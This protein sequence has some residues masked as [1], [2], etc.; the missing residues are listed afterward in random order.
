M[1]RPSPATTSS[2]LALPHG[3]SGAIA[4]E[5]PAEHA[6]ARLRRRPPP[7]DEADWAR[8]YGGELRRRLAL[9]PARAAPRRRHRSATPSRAPR[10][11]AVPGCNVTAVTLA[12]AP[13]IAR[14]RHRGARPRRRARRRARAGRASAA[15]RPA[16]QRAARLGR[17]PTASAASHRHIPEILQN[18]A[19]R[20]RR[21]RE[22]S[23]SR[24]CSCRCPAASSRPATA[25]LAAGRRLPRA[26]ATR[27][28]PPTPTSP[29][30]TC[31]PR[32]SCPRTADDRRREHGAHRARGRRGARAASSSISAIDNLVKGTAGA[33]V[34]SLN[35]ALGLPETTGLTSG[36]SR[37]RERHRSP[38]AS[39][40]AGVA[41]GLKSSGAPDLALV[42]NR[43]PLQRRGRRLHEQPRARPTRHLVAAGRSPT[44]RSRRSC[45]TRAAPTAS[46]ARRASRPRTPPPS[47]SREALEV[48]AG[49]V[50]VCS[51]GP[52]RR[53]AAAR[54]VLAGVAAAAAALG[55]HGGDAA[56]RAIMTTDSEPK[57]VV[58]RRARL[59][60]SAAWRRA[61]GCSRPA[62]PR[63][64]S[65][66]TTD[67]VAPEPPARPGAARRDAREL[68]PARL[69]R[70]HVDQRPGHA[71]WRAGAS[72][73]DAR[74][75]TEFTAAAHRGLRRPRRAAAGATPRARA[76]TSRSTV[77]RTPRPRTTPSRSAARSPATTSSRRPIFGN[78]PNWGRVLAAIGTTDAAVRPVRRRRLR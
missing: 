55:A 30:C 69:R 16:R 8:F 5:L 2:F 33:A 25:R 31:C 75:S 1:P 48:S 67:A 9:R 36:R 72:G 49:D 78:D 42:V 19:G 29:S 22:R 58:R 35:L 47:R 68:R 52:H 15:H 7:A 76:T 45:S 53:P 54:Q 70:L 27:G 18:L 28:T 50:L 63:C 23:R 60:A 40:R 10:R 62:S 20:G 65:C 43:G 71:A 38:R 17:A 56:S 64:S 39:W 11:I 51:T 77:D 44:A 41:A 14:R 57:R 37:P 73:V 66:I 6:R 21:R 13:G 74:R 26:C 24:P 46:P 32:G 59:D 61:P 34:Q 12:L 3:T 4:A